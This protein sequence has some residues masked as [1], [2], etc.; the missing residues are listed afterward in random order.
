MFASR[1][2]LKRESVD[3]LFC[4]KAFQRRKALPAFFHRHLTKVR[5]ASTHARTHITAAYHSDAVMELQ[6]AIND[7][8]NWNSIFIH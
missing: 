4:A 6:D 3:V 1:V 7:A 5:L 8:A 2:T